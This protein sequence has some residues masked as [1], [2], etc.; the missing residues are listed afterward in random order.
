MI[1]TIASQT[2]LLAQHHD[3][4]GLRVV[5]MTGYARNAIVQQ[6]VLDPGVDLLPKPFP[7]SA[8]TEKIRAALDAAATGAQG[9]GPSTA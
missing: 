5:Y 4:S 7:V 6:G 2:N 8:L 9:P 3:R 1:N